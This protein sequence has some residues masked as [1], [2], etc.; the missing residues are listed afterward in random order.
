MACNSVSVDIAM[1]LTSFEKASEMWSHLHTLG[2]QQNLAREFELE[3]LLAESIQ[4]EKN[5]FSASIPAAGLKDFMTTM[6]RT[7]TVQFLMKLR[8]ELEHL[9]ASIL[10][11][12]KLPALEVV[13][14]EVLR[15]ETRLCSQS[16]IEN[17]LTMDTAF[18]AYKSSSSSGNSNKPVQCYHCK[19]TGH[20]ISHCKKRNYCNYCKK[21]SHII[22][23]CRKKSGP[24]KRS[25]PH[26]AFQAM[27]RDAGTRETPST[28]VLDRNDIYKMIQ[29]SLVA[30]LPNAI[31]LTL[32]AT[33]PGK[34]KPSDSTVWHIDSAASNHMTRNQKLFFDLSKPR[35]RHEIV[36]TNGHVLTA[37]AI[38]TIKPFS[39]VLCVPKLTAN[40]LSVGQ[41]V[42]QNFLVIFSPNGCVIQNI[43]AGCFFF[44]LR[45]PNSISVFFQLQIK[46]SNFQIKC[47]TCGI[48][49]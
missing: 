15:E 42:E 24:G 37:S 17:S 21:D 44:N 12:E 45:I 20:I 41:L 25:T 36:T 22:L 30:A 39:E 26:K 23:E 31:S 7:R 38:G 32:T 13:V 16:S 49:V 46:I 40:L 29:E 11:K 27:A 10:N 18:A 48:S 35:S 34:T 4:A 3:R 8:P 14:S 43:L 6:K 9:R 1:E 19:E 28:K 47:G 33:Y 2:N 5:V